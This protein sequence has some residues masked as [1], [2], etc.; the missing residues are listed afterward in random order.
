MT[1]VLAPPVALGTS[2]TRLGCFNAGCDYGKPTTLPW[3][4]V[5]SSAIAH[6][7]TG[8]PLGVRIHPTQLYESLMTLAIFGVLLWWFPRKKHDGDIFL[9]YLGLYAVGR[10]I[11]EYVR[12]DEDR[13][14]VFNHL[15]STSQ[16]I[17]LLMLGGIAAVF[18]WRRVHGGGELSTVSVASNPPRV[19]PAG[20]AAGRA[21][22]RK[23]R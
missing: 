18:I 14:F 1:D 23:R 16:F 11:I 2:V 4:V 13:G 22:R 19:P 17:A 10:F 5:F 3:G 20:R 12:G 21:G 9:G 8:V 7:N 15:L 6:A